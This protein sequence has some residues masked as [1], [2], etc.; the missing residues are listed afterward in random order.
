MMKANNGYSVI[1]IENETLLHV[2]RSVN[3][4]LWAIVGRTDGD[5][6]AMKHALCGSSILCCTYTHFTY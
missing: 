5:M 2:L 6:S 4:E 1:D 3:Q